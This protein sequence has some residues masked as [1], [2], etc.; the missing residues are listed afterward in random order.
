[1]DDEMSRRRSGTEP[2]AGTPQVERSEARPQLS[3][4]DRHTLA[5]KISLTDGTTFAEARQ[6][7]ERFLSS[8]S[9]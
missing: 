6:Q 8:G 9:P 2:S 4:V 5:E 7:V 1:M 3:A